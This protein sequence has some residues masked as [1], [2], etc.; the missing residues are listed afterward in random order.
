MLNLGSRVYYYSAAQP[1]STTTIIPIVLRTLSMF[2][3]TTVL[4]ARLRVLSIAVIPVWSVSR[5]ANSVG[6]N[7]ETISGSYEPTTSH[8]T[9]RR[10]G[11][12]PKMRVCSLVACRSSIIPSLYLSLWVMR[13]LLDSLL[14]AQGQ[15]VVGDSILN[16]LTTLT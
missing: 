3:T 5:M 8:W 15:P 13:D 10:I 16:C 7:L 1:S 4:M 14:Q 12:T 6:V 11:A 2:C 9:R